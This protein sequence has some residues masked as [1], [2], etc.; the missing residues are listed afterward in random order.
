M[1]PPS[2][3]EALSIPLGGHQTVRR[4]HGVKTGARSALFSHPS[5]T[6]TAQVS[7]YPH[8]TSYNYRLRGF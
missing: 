3:Q 4:A 7:V 6:L 2:L 8:Y 5:A 1:F